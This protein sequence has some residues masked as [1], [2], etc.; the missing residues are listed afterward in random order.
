MVSALRNIG[1]VD[2]LVVMSK[3]V[4]S[5]TWNQD[6]TTSVLPERNT[7]LFVLIWRERKGIVKTSVSDRPSFDSKTQ[8]SK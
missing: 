8:T 6:T 1:E 7:P 5:I 4:I 2:G 3:V